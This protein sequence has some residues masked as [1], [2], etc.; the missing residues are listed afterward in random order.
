LR[1]GIGESDQKIRHL[2]ISRIALSGSG[3][4]HNASCRICKNDIHYL[5]ELL[6][7]GERRAAEFA[8]FH[9]FFLPL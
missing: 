8:N 3:N 2:R 1:S 4:N 9:I 6:G 7:I 5:F